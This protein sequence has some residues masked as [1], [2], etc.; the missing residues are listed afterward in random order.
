MARRHEL[1]IRTLVP[2]AFLG[3]SSLSSAAAPLYCCKDDNGRKICA[4]RVPSQCVGRD[5][6]I[7]TDAGTKVVEGMLTQEERALREVEAK[8]KREADEARMEQRRKDQALRNTYASEKDIDVAKLRT[9][10]VVR[11]TIK[12]AEEKIVAAEKRKKKFE[13]E[14]EFYKNKTLPDDVRRGI[15]DAEFEIKAQGE[16]IEAKKK[17]LADTEA[18]FDQEKKRFRELQVIP[19]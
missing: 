3:A 13:S 17:E 11:D 9:E 16:L 15:K 4:D 8:K 12:Q 6:T 5:Y 14:G 10:K 7:K 18:R 1:L 19:R 2:L